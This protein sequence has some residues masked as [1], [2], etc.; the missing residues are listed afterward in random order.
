MVDILGQSLNSDEGGDPSCMGCGYLI[1]EGNV[2][3][4]GAG[5]WHVHC[6][7]CAKCH[8]LVEHDSNLLLLSDGNPICERCSYSCNVC[9]KPILDEAIMTDSTYRSYSLS[10]T[11]P[12]SNSL[13]R[14]HSRLFDAFSP[15][16]SD[17]K[18][19]ETSPVSSMFSKETELN[20]SEMPVDELKKTLISTKKQLLEA[21]SNVPSQLE[22]IVTKDAVNNES[23]LRQKAEAAVEQLQSKLQSNSQELDELKKEKDQVQQFIKDSQLTRQH[24]NELENNLKELSVQKELIIKEIEGLANE[25][26]AD[27]PKSLA[28]HISTHL[29]EVKQTYLN[30]IRSL[31]LER[32]ALKIETELLRKERE[33]LLEDTQKL[34]E[35]NLELAEMNNE[36]NKQIELQHKS[37]LNNGFNFFKSNKSATPSLTSISSYY[38]NSDTNNRHNKSSSQHHHHKTPS[39]YNYEAEV[40]ENSTVSVQVQRN[41][42]AR[43]ETPKK[44]KWKK[45]NVFNKI[46]ATTATAIENKSP[47]NINTHNSNSS[48]SLPI[49]N[50]DNRAEAK[51][52]MLLQMLQNQ[53]SQRK[54]NWEQPSP[55][56]NNVKC[57]YCQER[58]LSNELRCTLCGSCSHIKCHT[59]ITAPCYSNMENDSDSITSSIS[60]IVVF[61]NDLT[62][63]AELEGEEVPIVVQKCIKAVEIR[64]IYRKSG[65]ASQMRSIVTAFDKNLEIDLDSSEQ[66]NDISAVT[67]VLKQYL[68]E[69]PN[70]LFTFELYSNFIELVSLENNEEKS[71]TFKQ[72]LLKLPKVNYATIKYLMLHLSRV[73]EHE[74]ENLMN[75]KNLSVVFGPTLLRGPNPNTEILDM[76]YKNSVIEYIIENANVLFSPIQSPRHEGRREGF[77]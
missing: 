33:Q 20:V 67:S 71:E 31:Q 39:L 64:G 50:H 48:I 9:K 75:S 36:I 30:D 27:L 4:F 5:I 14:R 42:I 22:N 26:Q 65:G 74:S 77:I 21:E 41:S 18:A 53:E 61:G 15:M 62:K 44:F 68:R 45:G 46:L 16:S 66:F 12:N 54:H 25:K 49:T 2:V 23:S 73:K 11:N 47:Y 72:L 29:D 8:N 57:D 24:L 43:G 56:R 37:K 13:G 6:F 7:R 1:E 51:Q 59:F 19:N 60:N 28:K 3:A 63:Q 35:K 10:A 34:N 40:L 55:P 58:I 70:P 69:L 76:N 52:K 32:D 17:R 38:E